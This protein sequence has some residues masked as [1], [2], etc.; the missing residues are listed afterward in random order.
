M[1]MG[2]GVLFSAGLLPAENALN[3]PLPMWLSKASAK[4]LRAVLWVQRKSTFNGLASVTLD[5]FAL[6]SF[7]NSFGVDFARLPLATVLGQVRQ[8]SIHAVELGSINQVS[9][10]A[11]LRNQVCVH[12]LFQMKRKSVC[13]HA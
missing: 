2:L 10:T 13:G 9:A 12:Q 8:H 11:L 1:A 7:T 4:M 3:F 6:T 5:S